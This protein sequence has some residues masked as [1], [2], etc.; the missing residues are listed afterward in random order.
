MIEIEGHNISAAADGEFVHVQMVEDVHP[1]RRMSMK[2]SPA[3]ADEAADLIRGA[4]AQVRELGVALAKSLAAEAL[5]D[6]ERGRHYDAE[7]KL[8]RAIEGL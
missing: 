4:T 1:A 6:L 8:R 7:A 3:E 5:K 2:L